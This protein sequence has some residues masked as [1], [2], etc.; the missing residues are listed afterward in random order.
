MTIGEGLSIRDDP[1]VVDD[2][3]RRLLDMLDPIANPSQSEVS[4]VTPC[5]IPVKGSMEELV[6][7]AAR[8][9]EANMLAG[10]M[11]PTT[12]PRPAATIKKYSRSI[13]ATGA[14]L[15]EFTP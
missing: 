14:N 10:S 8:G 3:H 2:E 6:Q 13:L 12:L 15:Y 5:L 9:V 4:F 11:G 1:V 7:P